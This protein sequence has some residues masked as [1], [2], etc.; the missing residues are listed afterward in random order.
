MRFLAEV[1]VDLQGRDVCFAFE[2]DNGCFPCAPAP[3]FR[4]GNSQREFPVGR[5]VSDDVFSLQAM[6]Q[7]N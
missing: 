7:G 1:L 4:F 5:F 2:I 6:A 3:W